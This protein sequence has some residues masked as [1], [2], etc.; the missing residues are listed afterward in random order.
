MSIN[1]ALS[2]TISASIVLL[3]GVIGVA[4]F[5]EPFWT[6]AVQSTNAYHARIEKAPLFLVV[7]IGLC[8]AALL[9]EMQ[10]K[11]INAKV[12]ATLGVLTAVISVLRFIEVAF[13][14]PGG[15]SPIF[16]P[17]ILAGYVFGARFGFLLGAFTL[18]VSGIVTGGVGP[19][20]PFQM[21]TAGWVGMSAG[22]LGL[23]FHTRHGW[24]AVLS[25]SVLGV[26]WGLLYGL[27][28]NLY[29]WPY[30]LGP[31]EQTWQMGYSLAKTMRHYAAFYLAT[32]LW[33]DAAR[34]FGNGLLVAVMGAPTLRALIRFRDRFMFENVGVPGA[35]RPGGSAG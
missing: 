24:G 31:A 28:M 22:W 25:L 10:G 8:F 6:G 35:G 17:I 16:A 30:A 7:L 19:W 2:Q 21:F 3:T 15:F 29:F 11:T 20:L 18:L 1:R 13:P 14:A 32:S 4:A 27:I 26:F 33:W 12:V 5:L 9:V 34:A 23:F